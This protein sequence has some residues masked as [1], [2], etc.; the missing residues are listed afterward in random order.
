MPPRHHLSSRYRGAEI[1]SGDERI[2]LGTYETAHEAAR[3]RRDGLAPPPSSPFDELPDVWTR[4]QA[5]HLA[6]PPAVTQEARQRQRKLEQ[7]LLVAE[8]DER[9]CLEWARHFPKDVAAEVAFFAEK[10]EMK[11]AKK[12]DRGARRA[13][14]EAAKKDNEEKAARRKEEK[15]KGAVPW[16][17]AVDSSSSEFKWSSTPVSST[18][19]DSSE[20]EW[21]D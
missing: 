12:K 21:S 19:T 2:G 15:K 13:K 7:R 10:A 3:V 5:E 1:W 6:P 8:R 11:A 20:F 4:Q 16:T 17:I 14:K 9:M 18:T